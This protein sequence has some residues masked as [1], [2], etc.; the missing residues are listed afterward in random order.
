[1]HLGDDDRPHRRCGGEPA[2]RRE[3][4][5][6]RNRQARAT[7]WQRSATMRSM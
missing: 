1:G 7:G 2:G 6:P 5:G 4:P 3:P